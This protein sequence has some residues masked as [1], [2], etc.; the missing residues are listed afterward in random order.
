MITMYVPILF[1]NTEINTSLKS[2]ATSPPR[3]LP[4]L[5]LN[6]NSKEGRHQN[7]EYHRSPSW[8]ANSPPVSRQQSLPLL[9]AAARQAQ[10]SYATDPNISDHER[11]REI[12]RRQ[13]EQ[14]L[15]DREVDLEA[16]GRELE[17][18]RAQ[19]QA[20][21]GGGEHTGYV[22]DGNDTRRSVP[23]EKPGLHRQERRVSLRHQ[24]RRPLSRMELD[25]V[26][27][28]TRAQESYTQHLIPPADNLHT[29]PLTL[30]PTHSPKPS[31]PSPLLQCEGHLQES[32]TLNQSPGD[33]SH[34][35]T[36]TSTSSVHA[37]FCG[38]EK[39]SI[40]K[41]REPP[42]EQQNSPNESRR[43]EKSRLG[44]GWIR[45]LSMPVSNI[46]KHQSNSTIGVAN[47]HSLGSGIVGGVSNKGMGLFSLDSKK[48][49]STTGLGG[50]D[51]DGKLGRPG[52]V[53][54]N[55]R[56]FDPSGMSNRSMTNLKLR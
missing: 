21:C 15:R 3:D 20:L 19:L 35:Y 47:T 38:C 28:P 51:E 49:M 1:G 22:H 37:S 26:P 5:P 2:G 32:R 17:R 43:S 31:H 25:E 50:V 41:Y 46:K 40:S 29:P 55:R 14:E 34:S 8:S 18:D 39:C 36:S 4:R 13:K 24:L 11:N 23:G 54:L 42:R 53:V 12:L 16:R 10:E 30:Q 7:N 6:I 33:V 48:N 56:S 45:R 9:D 52:G 44:T 27:S